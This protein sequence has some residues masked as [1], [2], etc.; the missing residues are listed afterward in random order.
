[1]N[2]ESNITNKGNNIINYLENIANIDTGNMTD[3]NNKNPSKI[4]IITIL[5]NI[6]NKEI[7]VYFSGNQ[8]NKN[9]FPFQQLK[10]FKQKMT[11]I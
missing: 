3:S 11:V 7:F 6:R 1:M 10:L 4:E 2:K 5:I 9:Q 8:S